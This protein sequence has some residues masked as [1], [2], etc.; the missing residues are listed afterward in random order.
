MHKLSDYF[1]VLNN[2]QTLKRRLCYA[3][4]ENTNLKIYKSQIYYEKNQRY[5]DLVTNKVN[6]EIC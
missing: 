5:K 4:F 6:F 3:T 1:N 2:F